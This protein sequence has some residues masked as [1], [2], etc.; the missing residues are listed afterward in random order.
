MVYNGVLFQSG[1][2][3][4]NFTGQ[5]VVAA[6]TSD[7]HIIVLTDRYLYIFGADG[8]E[9]QCRVACC[10]VHSMFVLPHTI[11]QMQSGIVL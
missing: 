10:G 11:F 9:L 7:E 2:A 6:A 1:S 8:G 5:R 4:Y 3:V